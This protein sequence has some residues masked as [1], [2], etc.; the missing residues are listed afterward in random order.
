MKTAFEANLIHTRELE[1]ANRKHAH[2]LEEA[3]RKHARTLEEANQI[4]AREL[5]EVGD[6]W[7]KKHKREVDETLFATLQEPSIVVS[8]SMALYLD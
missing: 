8:H 3:N 7:K 1:D 2:E 5:A 4:H 6:E